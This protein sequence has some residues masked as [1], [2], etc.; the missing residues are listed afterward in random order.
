MVEDPYSL[1]HFRLG[2]CF[3][4]AESSFVPASAALNSFATFCEI[5]TFFANFI[6]WA[7]AAMN[8]ACFSDF[9]GMAGPDQ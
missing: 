9:D 8:R 5:P 7:A 1:Y 4:A 3:A 2:R 6:E